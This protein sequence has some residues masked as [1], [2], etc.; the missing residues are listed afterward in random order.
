MEEFCKLGH[1]VSEFVSNVIKYDG[2]DALC[3]S[4]ERKIKCEKEKGS[5]F[6]FVFSFNYFPD[7][8]RVA[9][10]NDLPYVSW[11]YDSPH[12]TLQSNTLNNVCNRVFLFDRSLYERYLSEGFNTVKY[13][14]LPARIMN[15]R[16]NKQAGYD[17][18]VTF[19]GSLYD[20][21]QDQ[22]EKIISF[23]EHLKGFLDAVIAA[24]ERVYGFDIIDHLI[25]EQKYSE[26]SKYVNADLGDNYRKCGIEIFKDMM[27][28]KT[29]SN[30]RIRALKTLGSRFN[31]ELYSGKEPKDIP[32]RFRG[33]A[34]Y[35]KKM[36]EVFYSSKINLNISL[37]SIKTG[38]PLRVMDIL[39]SGGFCITNYQEE[40][41]EFFEN[42]NDLIWY[43][44]IDD[45]VD[46]TEYY[47]K[48]D[49]ER[50]RIRLSGTERVRELFS[51]ENQLTTLIKGV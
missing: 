42:E 36:P 6:D 28:R 1:S 8:S 50:E 45:L 13:L 38:I 16:H 51:Y 41:A 24:E 34:D 31:V 26:I 18:D 49:E 9:L 40:I 15:V 20:G 17:G 46:K 7:V 39:G 11:V 29:T 5:A 30:E 19:V 44:S 37:R 48:H 21:E 27:R 35:E 23:P 47:L 25:D 12:L 10:R 22:Y 3:E 4:L 2:D 14:P 43:E 33:Y 32:V